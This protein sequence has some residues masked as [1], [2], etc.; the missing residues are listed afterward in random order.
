ML[1][2]QGQ[3]MSMALAPWQQ[4]APGQM[5]FQTTL[6]G[7]DVNMQQQQQQLQQPGQQPLQQQTTTG[8]HTQSIGASLTSFLAAPLKIFGTGRSASG[9]RQQD[10]LQQQQQQQQGQQPLPQQQQ[11]TVPIGTNAT[12]QQQQQLVPLQQM[13]TQQQQQQQTLPPSSVIKRSLFG[14]EKRELPN[15]PGTSAMPA[16]AQEAR[17]K[18][19]ASIPE[20]TR[21]QDTT[22]TNLSGSGRMLPL[23]PGQRSLDYPMT[24]AAK[25]RERMKIRSSTWTEETSYTGGP[26]DPTSYGP[27]G[28]G[29][30]RR[31]QPMIGATIGAH[32]QRPSS[33]GVLMSPTAGGGGG[34]GV[35]HRKISASA[36]IPPYSGGKHQLPSTVGSRRV[37]P[38]VPQRVAVAATRRAKGPLHQ[39]SFHSDGGGGGGGSGGNISLGLPHHALSDHHLAHHGQQSQQQQQSHQSGYLMKSTTDPTLI[40]V[41]EGGV[42]IHSA[43]VDDDDDDDDEDWC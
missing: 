8:A 25:A 23:Q 34:G 17:M 20:L 1:A 31:Q 30:R 39:H 14:S 27:Y 13:Q 41:G 26:S 18:L 21:L 16:W 3:M 12:M 37:T 29:P 2:G 7:Y 10:Q 43:T 35:G 19:G 38:P 5:Q 40:Q 9:S 4:M 28:T 36:M 6:A 15:V 11:M 33:A 22:T 24:Y 42:I 32:L